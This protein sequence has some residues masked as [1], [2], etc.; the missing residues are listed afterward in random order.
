MVVL[1]TKQYEDVRDAITVAAALETVFKQM[2]IVGHRQRTIE[3]YEYIFNPFMTVN[4]IQYVEDISVESI[5]HYLDVLEVSPRT[6]LIRLK[7][8]K[9]VL[10]K[11]YNNSWI[12]DRIWATIHIKVD[13]E[14]KEGAKESDIDK[15][16]HLIDQTTFIGFRDA[17]AIS[18]KQSLATH[19]VTEK[20]EKVSTDIFYYVQLGLIKPF[21]MVLYVKYLE[22]FN[23]DCGYAFPTIY[24]L[25]DY[26]NCSRQSIVSANNRLVAVGLLI[27]D[28]KVRMLILT[29]Y[30]LSTEYINLNAIT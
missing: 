13:K 12:K 21:D 24:Q 20:F 22:L 17:A 19:N 4:R 14:V 26:L 16:L 18:P 15:L 27:P 10:S 8:I 11:F 9:A 29:Y 28:V 25:E 1:P 5:Y 30:A 23:K 2:Q 7:S 6:K 3:S